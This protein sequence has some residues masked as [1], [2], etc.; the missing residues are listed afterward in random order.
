M[1]VTINENYIYL[2]DISDEHT[3][4]FKQHGKYDEK[5][6]EKDSYCNVSIT[7]HI[8]D[9]PFDILDK[10]KQ[11]LTFHKSMK[12]LLNESISGKLLSDIKNQCKETINIHIPCGELISFNKVINL[13]DICT[14]I[15]QEHLDGG[16]KIIA[17]IPQV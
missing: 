8:S 15:L 7:C 16:W 4:F 17:C 12:A 9:I 11:H 5:I 1:I 3:E 14:N 10:F 13:D 6:R 2:T